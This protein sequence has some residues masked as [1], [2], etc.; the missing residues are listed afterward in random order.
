MDQPVKSG[1]IPELMMG[2]KNRAAL[3]ACKDHADGVYFSVDRFSLRARACDITL[4]DLN[5]FVSDIKEQGMNAYLALNTVI[6]PDDLPEL[7]EVIDVVASSDVDAVIAWDPAV[8][9]KAV[10]AGLRVHISTQANVSNWQTV[11]FYA[12]LGASRVVLARELSLE[13]IKEIRKNT[14]TEL[15]V[16]IH[17]AMCQAISGRCYL[18][19]YV[20]GKSGNCGECSQPCRWGWKLVGEDGSEVDLE[21]KYLLSARDLCMI[22]HIPELIDA[23]V[24]AFKVEGRLRDTRYTSTVSRCYRE[25]L[26]AYGEGTYTKEKAA[27]WKEEMASVFNRGFS[28]GFY[29][30]VPGPD[31]MYIE[32][33]M[34]ISVV[35]RQAVGVVTNYYRKQSAAEVKLLES[36]I[37]VGD[38]IIIEGKN[39]YLEQKVVEIRNDDGSVQR[40]EPGEEVGLA[41]EGKVREN[42]RVYR[43]D[44]PD[45]AK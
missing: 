38:E 37:E 45:P 16:F 19:A 43:L 35:K 28:T 11:N 13:Q 10:D 22:E 4:D 32:Q 3:S 12:S 36:G 14:D 44:V 42:D 9:T 21:G 15:E 1:K 39:T 24:D 17:G 20:L 41:V 18:S 25:A 26:D 2:V 7:D 29:F 23:G 33:D 8:I 30:G 6:Y 5:S 34:N 40:A 31:G 27:G